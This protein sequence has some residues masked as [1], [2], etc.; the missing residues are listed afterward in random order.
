MGNTQNEVMAGEQWDVGTQVFLPDSEILS[1]LFT[2]LV[3]SDVD[4]CPA[5]ASPI[6]PLATGSFA[7][8]GKGTGL[9]RRIWAHGNCR[10]PESAERPLGLPVIEKAPR[11][12]GRRGWAGFPQ[13]QEQPPGHPQP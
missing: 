7:R 12:K 9:R 1:R 8:F 11:R 5:H 4:I 3:L 6:I 10:G 13:G 2:V